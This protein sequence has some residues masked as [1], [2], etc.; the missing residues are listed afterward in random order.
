MSHQAVM[1]NEFNSSEL[2]EMYPGM[3]KKIIGN[4]IKFYLEN[5]GELMK[6]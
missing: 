3:L 6:W 2:C 4:P 1:K 5:P